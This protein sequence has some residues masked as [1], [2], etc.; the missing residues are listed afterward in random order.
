MPAVKIFIVAHYQLS[1]SLSSPSFYNKWVLALSASFEMIVWVCL[2]SALFG[3]LWAWIYSLMS[4]N[5]AKLSVICSDISF[6]VFFSLL[7]VGSRVDVGNKGRRKIKFPYYLELIDKSSKQAE[8]HPSKNPAASLFILCKGQ[9]AILA[10]SPGPRKSTL[11]HKDSF[12][13]FSYLYSSRCVLAII[14]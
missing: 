7:L 1:M 12:G 14:P 3:V 13:N 11:T 10:Q 6:A 4:I 2:L 5:F 9:K 8:W